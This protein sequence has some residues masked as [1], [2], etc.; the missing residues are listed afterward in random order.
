MQLLL[1][2]VL[3]SHSR[4]VLSSPS[5]EWR[6]RL[7]TLKVE[8]GCILSHLTMPHLFACLLET[9]FCTVQAGL[10]P[11]IFLAPAS[12]VLG[13]QT[14]ITIPRHSISLIQK[15]NTLSKNR[16]Y[17]AL[18]THACNPTYSGGRNQ[19]DC[20]SKPA[21]ANSS[22]NPISKKPFTKK[23]WWSG[24]RCRPSSNP[25]IAKNK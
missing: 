23:G 24:Q 1:Q 8:S 25:S 14:C 13:L 16:N 15:W 4:G 17:Q 21:Q 5:H 9:V 20:S 7:R 3:H 22:H 2:E 6:P 18:V 19:E 12:Q 11:K 10:K